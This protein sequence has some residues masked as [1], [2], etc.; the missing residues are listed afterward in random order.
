M[1]ETPPEAGAKPR[2]FGDALGEMIGGMEASTLML[3][4]MTNLLMQ[5]ASRAGQADRALFEQHLD[6]LIASIERLP[7][8]RDSAEVKRRLPILKDMLLEGVTERKEGRDE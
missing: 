4:G 5:L 1:S 6:D 8:M 3:V 7:Q 2:R